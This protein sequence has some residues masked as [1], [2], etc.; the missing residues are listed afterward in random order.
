[1]MQAKD[2]KR[3]VSEGKELCKADNEMT[4]ESMSGK[5]K[6]LARGMLPIGMIEELEKK[7]ENDKISIL[8]NDIVRFE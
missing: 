1:M 3:I 8:I 5:L 4:E 7:N 6:L 2:V